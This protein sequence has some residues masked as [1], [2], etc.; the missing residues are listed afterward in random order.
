MIA[1]PTLSKSKT[2][3]LAD[4][5]DGFVGTSLLIRP[6]SSGQTVERTCSLHSSRTSHE[7][8]SRRGGTVAL[9]NAPSVEAR[10]SIEWPI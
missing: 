10:D 9:S 6:A 2:V 4:S 1:T 3:D 8:I 7:S 5:Q